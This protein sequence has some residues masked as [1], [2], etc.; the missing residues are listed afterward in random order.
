VSLRELCDKFKSWFRPKKVEKRIEYLDAYRGFLVSLMILVNF[1]LFFKNIPLWLKHAPPLGGVTV[2]DIGAP[3]FFFVIGLV[4]PYSFGRRLKK[5]GAQKTFQHFIIRYLVLW[6][7]G[8]VGVLV[9][10]YQ[11]TFGWN[12]LMAIGLAGLYALPFMFLGHIWRL[13]CGILLLAIYQ[14]VILRY[15]QATVLAYDMGGFL[16]A[17]SWAS[18]ILISSFWWPIIKKDDHSQFSWT[19]LV[20]ILVILALGFTLG[21]FYPTNKPLVSASYILLSYAIGIGGLLLFHWL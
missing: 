14:F 4:Y 13:L 3:L 15:F 11:L 2:V 20:F 7:F 19:G 17:I 8:F 21:Q 1:W 9:T 10:T 5:D 12:V 18:M 16:G 6:L